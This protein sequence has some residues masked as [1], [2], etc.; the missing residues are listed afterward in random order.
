VDSKT[1]KDVEKE[2]AGYSTTV[3][4][5]ER[6]N[7]G[8]RVAVENVSENEAIVGIYEPFSYKVII[9][10]GPQTIHT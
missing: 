3:K 7:Y 1:K 4:K 2:A 10:L 8:K 9:Q 5:N 6:K